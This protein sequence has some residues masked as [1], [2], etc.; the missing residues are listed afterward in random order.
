[1][2][3]PH[4]LD[5]PHVLEAL[6]KPGDYT[7]ARCRL[8]HVLPVFWLVPFPGVFEFTAWRLLAVAVTEALH[9]AFGG[10]TT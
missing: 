7:K 1:V 4:G 6:P 2:L 5:E 8:T 3:L 10:F 9:R